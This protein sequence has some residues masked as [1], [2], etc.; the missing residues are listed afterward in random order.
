MST[1]TEDEYIVFE[2]PDAR[3]ERLATEARRNAVDGKTFSMDKIKQLYDLQRQVD[4]KHKRMFAGYVTILIMTLIC[5]MILSL[6]IVYHNS[7]VI[8][9]SFAIV[10]CIGICAIAISANTDIRTRNN[11]MKAIYNIYT[12]KN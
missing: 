3:D 9:D 7:S 6:G 11:T 12:S 10:V 8:T 1:I 5:I 2:R 4:I